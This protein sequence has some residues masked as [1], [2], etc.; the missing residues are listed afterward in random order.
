MLAES[1]S[2]FVRTM[3]ILPAPAFPSPPIRRPLPSL[4]TIRVSLCRPPPLLFPRR[5]RSGRGRRTRWPGR[6]L[7]GRSSWPRRQ[8][9]KSGGGEE[10]MHEA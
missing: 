9:Q 6:R 4:C 2:R 3:L 10:T 7:Q 8:K 1:A 5:I